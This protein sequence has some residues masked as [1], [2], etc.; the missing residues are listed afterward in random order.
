MFIS[1]YLLHPFILKTV[2]ELCREYGMSQASTLELY[3]NERY[4]IDRVNHYSFL[5]KIWSAIIL[6][7]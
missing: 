6:T 7:I 5:F 3:G 4:Y 2:A 1:L